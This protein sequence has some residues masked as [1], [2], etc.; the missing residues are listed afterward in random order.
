MDPIAR[1][2]YETHAADDLDHRD[3]QVMRDQLS[4]PYDWFW[5]HSLVT[6]VRDC[7]RDLPGVRRLV[8]VGGGTGFEAAILRRELTQLEEIVVLDIGFSMMQLCKPTFSHLGVPEEGVYPVVADFNHLPFRSFGEDTVGL[9]FRSLH[10]AGDITKPLAQMR[11]VFRRIICIEPVWNAPIRF[12]SRLGVANRPEHIADHRPQRLEPSLVHAP[13]WSVRKR[14]MLF[15]PRDRLPGLQKR[16]GVF[17][18]GD[19]SPREALL[20]K[21]YCRFL[22]AVDYVVAPLG[23]TNYIQLEMVKENSRP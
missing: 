8:V 18:E 12:L 9:A 22:Q 17:H 4:H 10:H 14:N 20:A 19:V 15:I 21:A 3:I 16:E 13:G 2:E 1:Q 5:F 11:Q 23:F 7:L 6:G